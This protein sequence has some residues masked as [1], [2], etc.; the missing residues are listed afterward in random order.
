MSAIAHGA[1]H[2]VFERIDPVYLRLKKIG[3]EMNEKNS[4]GF[5]AYRALWML[6]YW[7]K[8]AF[9]MDSETSLLLL[10]TVRDYEGFK[11][12]YEINFHSK[13]EKYL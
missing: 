9:I 3:E 7:K 5:Y 2:N 10:T 6:G 12:V 13:K 1:V 11:M 8:L 4:I